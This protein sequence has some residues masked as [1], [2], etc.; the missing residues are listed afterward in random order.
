MRETQGEAV[1]AIEM[2][3]K[4]FTCLQNAAV[5]SAVENLLWGRSMRK[6]PGNKK[7]AAGRISGVI[8]FQA[9]TLG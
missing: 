3:N 4:V 6:N 2:F 1:S 5:N 8:V 9:G 7:P